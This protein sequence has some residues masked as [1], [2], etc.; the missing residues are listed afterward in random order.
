MVAP[1]G[2]GRP[3]DAKATM[4]AWAETYGPVPGMSKVV[5]T[6]GVAGSEVD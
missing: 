3:G 5:S 6:P 4:G 1:G 2:A